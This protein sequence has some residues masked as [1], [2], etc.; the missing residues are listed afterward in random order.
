MSVQSHTTLVEFGEFTLRKQIR[1]EHIFDAWLGELTQDRQP[2]LVRRMLPPF[3]SS[4]AIVQE[5][6]SRALRLGELRASPQSPFRNQGVILPSHLG[7]QEG[8]PY[9]ASPLP[10]SWSLSH[11]LDLRIKATEE[12]T[13]QADPSAPPSPLGEA[14]PVAFV[15][16]IAQVVGHALHAAHSLPE[17]LIH[18]VLSPGSVW[19]GSGGEVYLTDF[20]L[21][22]HAENVLEPSEHEH[23]RA[24]RFIAPERHLEWHSPSTGVDLYSLGALTLEML[25]PGRLGSVQIRLDPP[26]MLPLLEA[27]GVPAP[28]V[29]VLQSI[30][31]SPPEHRPTLPQVLSTFLNINRELPELLVP[32]THRT[33]ETFQSWLSRHAPPLEVLDP[34]ARVPD[35]FD[36]DVQDR[37]QRARRLAAA[38][39]GKKLPEP[40][41]KTREGRPW[42]LILFMLL[43]TL[44]VLWFSKPVLMGLLQGEKGGL[45][46]MEISSQPPDATIFNSEGMALGQAPLTSAVRIDEQ[47]AVDLKARLKGYRTQTLH[48]KDL[49]VGWPYKAAFELEPVSAQISAILL[50]TSP[51]GAEVT[52]DGKPVGTSTD[53]KE[54]PLSIEHL[55]TQQSHE[56]QVSKEGF[57][58]VTQTVTLE[59]EEPLEL[60]LT[61]KSLTESGVGQ[62]SGARGK[63]GLA[64]EGSNSGKSA[65]SS[66]EKGKQKS[67]TAAEGAASNAAPPP[68]GPVGYLVISSVPGARITLDGKDFGWTNDSQR[69]AIG[70]GKHVVGLK[71]RKGQFVQHDVNI[72]EGETRML[73][74]DFMNSGWHLSDYRPF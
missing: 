18:G 12:R 60:N 8:V 65:S 69:R 50:T 38:A 17:P 16:K 2:M 35:A 57:Q 9:V 3:V 45:V 15:L 29:D 61:L 7:D 72:R 47:G 40:A 23:P 42:G 22:S 25:A 41:G 5:W 64:G 30:L 28:L 46:R 59:P 73:S 14:L 11:L 44:G 36:A 34:L 32:G 70:V 53:G 24:W 52:L 20:E 27:K 62:T 19:I 54:G 55:S 51:A 37:L 48:L 56:L 33:V 31:L 49:K 68:V 21:G 4:P 71:S 1:F 26:E 66:A 58:T 13:M 10:S 43:T 74:Y 39:Q 67:A 63:T 6:L